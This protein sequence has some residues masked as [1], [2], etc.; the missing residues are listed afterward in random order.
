[1]QEP[2]PAPSAGFFSLPPIDQL[3]A[4]QDNAHQNR[5]QFRDRTEAERVC[6]AR[7][8]VPC[9]TGQGSRLSLSE[10]SAWPKP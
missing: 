9:Y 10:E 4:M 2:A 8:P 7:P 1:M 6:L 3:R 5:G